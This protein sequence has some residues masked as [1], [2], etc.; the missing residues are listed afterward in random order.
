MFL[1][2]NDFPVPDFDCCCCKR[3]D[4][5]PVVARLSNWALIPGRQFS[6]FGTGRKVRTGLMGS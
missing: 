5:G 2:G 1:S 3:V 4:E 6:N